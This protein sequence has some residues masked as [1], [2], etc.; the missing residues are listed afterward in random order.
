MFLAA[1]RRASPILLSLAVKT[2]TIAAFYSPKLANARTNTAAGATRTAYAA[3]SISRNISL[4]SRRLISMSASRASEGAAG[5]AGSRQ[6]VVAACQILCGSD[7]LVNIATAES[8]VREAAAAGAQVVVLPE[9]WNGPYDTASFP[10]YAEPVPD[11]Q[12]DET[13]AEMPS[14]EQSPSAA[15]L[16]RAAAENKVWLVGGSVPEAGKDGGVYNTCIIVEPS[17]RIAAKHR[18]VHLFDIDVPGG[19]TFKE[20]D[21]LSPGDSITTVETPF[22]TIGVGICYDMRFPELSMAM[23][24]AGSVLLCFPGAFNMTTGP[25]HWELLQRARAL[26]N[27]CYVVTAS[28]ARN[29]DSKYQAWGHSSIVD[30]WGT[31]VATTEHEEAMLVAEVDVGRVAEVRTSI[32]VSLQKRPDLYRL[33]LP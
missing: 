2:S 1:A 28:P 8:A 25:A 19:I 16:C 14:A 33:E 12:G 22:G 32:P 4:L 6:F 26:D 17:G 18:K 20:S 27:Q 31:I 15:M 30:P 29:P 21:T 7:K 13:T 24:A 10:V 11:P 23:R 5:G 3:C 9:C